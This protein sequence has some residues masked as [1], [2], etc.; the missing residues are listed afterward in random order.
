MSK[1]S[2]DCELPFPHSWWI[3]PGRIIGGRYPGT[4]DPA[5]SEAMLSRL[6]EVGVRTVINLQVEKELG[7][8][9]RPFPDYVPA[10]KRLAMERGLEAHVYRHPISDMGIPSVEEMKA[11]LQVI[12]AAVSAGHC[13]YIHCWGGHGRTGTVAGCWHRRCGM[14]YQ[15]ALTTI[16]EARQHDDHLCYEDS[17]QTTE[18]RRFIREW[19]GGA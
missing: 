19:P 11:V 7:R 16:A 12:G 1:E 13:V 5:E 4:T 14:E 3:E 6:L 2:P 17:P 10:L 15:Q 18:Q 9:G 8:N